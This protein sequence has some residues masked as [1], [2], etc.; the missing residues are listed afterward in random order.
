MND[1]LAA[2]AK[3]NRRAA[4][5]PALLSAF[6]ALGRAGFKGTLGDYTINANGDTSLAKFDGYRVDASGQLVAA[7]PLS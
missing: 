4:Y 6:F 2:I 5:R 3:A 7:H 1:V